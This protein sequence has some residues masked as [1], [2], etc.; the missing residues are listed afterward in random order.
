MIFLYT[1]L[2]NRKKIHFISYL[3]YLSTKTIKKEEGT[4]Q[5][6]IKLPTYNVQIFTFSEQIQKGAKQHCQLT[7]DKD[8]IFNVKEQELK[9]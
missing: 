9:H 1:A 3:T 8:Q 2:E 7:T 6:V 4:N 5:N